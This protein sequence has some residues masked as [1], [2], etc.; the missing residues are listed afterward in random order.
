MDSVAFNDPAAARALVN[1]IAG[2]ARRLP[3][4]RLME[5]CGTH[6]MEIGRLGIRQL[7]PDSVRL[8]SGPGC[9]VC[10]TPAAY[11]DA[12]A[13]LAVSQGVCIATFGDLFRVPGNRR[14]FAQVKAAGAGIEVVASPRAALDLARKS[15]GEVVFTAVGFE[16]TIPATAA[17]V[18]AAAS[19]GITNLSF[20]VAHRLVPPALDVLLADSS[21]R[22]SGFLLPGHVSAI[23]GAGA[24]GTLIRRGVPG[25]ITG[26]EALD[27]L[28]GICG[29]LGLLAGNE[30]AIKNEYT[31]VVPEDGNPAARRL[32]EE[33]YEPCDAIWRGIGMLPQSGLRLRP[34][35]AAFDASVR[36]GLKE[37]GDEMPEGC[38]C[39][40]VLKGLI[41]PEECLLF[42]AACTPEN[43]V[44]P[45]MVSSEGSCAAAF[46]YGGAR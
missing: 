46:K 27:I 43:P 45:C 34:E 37:Q 14:S 19:E 12:A 9:P 17:A 22:I 42:G 35:F 23:V 5:V 20:F 11:I 21:L 36:Y 28:A 3:E 24:Y 44:G 8:I 6:T 15:S 38:G 33:V 16:T 18:K 32:M 41:P 1:T 7:L 13:E 10:V 31:R 25:V 2:L 4:V 39:G 40:R 30:V 29:L 26:F